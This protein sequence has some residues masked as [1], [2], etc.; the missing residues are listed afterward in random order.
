MANDSSLQEKTEAPTPKKRQDARQEG[1]V[2]RSQE[3]NTAVLLLGAAVVMTM[4]AP[5][6]G[7]G[8]RDVFGNGLFLAGM[9]GLDPDSS[10]AMIRDAGWRTLVAIAPILLGMAATALTI[11]TIQARGV[12][13]AKPLGPNWKK[14]DPITNAKRMLGVQ[15]WAELAKSLLKLLIIGIAVYFSLSRAWPEIVALSQQSPIALLEVAHRFGARLLM[16]AGGT[17][18]VLAALDYSYQLWQHEKQLKMTKQEVKE[19]AK[20]SDGDPMVKARL[21]AFGRQLARRQMFQAIPTADVV[22]T[23]PT[24]IAVALRY[25]PLQADAPIVVAM[26]QRKIAERIK[27]IAKENGVPTVEN[28]PL[29]RAL[30]SSARV[31]MTIPAELYMAVAEVLAFVFKQRAAR[32]DWSGSAVA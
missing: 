21:R 28:R 30:L 22:I 1:Q 16:T 13:S 6:A 12:L 25:D 2:P 14:L 17:Y 8:V 29:A 5:T 23:N 19:E 20:Q 15:P 31:G 26:G 4:V 27:A 24:H 18:L 10:V 3:L 7:A 32:G 9:G 11:T